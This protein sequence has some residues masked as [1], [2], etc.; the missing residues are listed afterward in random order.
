MKPIVFDLEKYLSAR[1]KSVGDCLV[2]TNKPN[3]HGYGVVSPNSWIVK[4]FG[5]KLL[6]RVVYTYNYDIIPSGMC[7]MH[8]CDNRMCVNIKHLKLGTWA[9]NNRDRKLKGRNADTHGENHP[10]N[11]LK[12]GDVRRI[13]SLKGLISG[14]KLSREYNVDHSTIYYIWNGKLWSNLL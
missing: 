13:R 9:D 10:N 11:K 6:H 8:T 14:T 7:I 4:T 12:E 2:F 1:T 3:A 5:E